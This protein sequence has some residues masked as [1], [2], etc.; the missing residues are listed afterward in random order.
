MLRFSL[1]RTAQMAIVVF[2]VVTLV[3]FIL[4][5]ASGDPA[6]L[7]VPPGQQEDLVQLTRERLGTD[8]PI[9]V[10]YGEYLVG[11]ARGD[12]GV[13]FHGGQPVLDEVL[14]ALPNTA[15]LAA[16]T[17]V[18]S[19]AV[20][21]VL[22]IGAALRANGAFDRVVLVY[23][24][25]ALATPSFWLAIVLVMFFSVRLGWLPAIDMEGPESFVLPVI[26]LAVALTPVLIRMIRLSFLETLSDDHV[27]AARARGIPERRVILVHGLKV[28]ALPLITLVGLQ[29]GLIL[30][31]SYVVE[32]VFNWPGIGKLT[33]DAVVSR[34]FPMIQGGVLVAALAFV[35][36]NF[37]VDLAYAAVDPRIRL[38]AR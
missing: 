12:L 3:F 19:S 32:F 25:V 24:S 11:L 5:L 10:Q 15:L 36:V 26:T 37:V 17:I 22:G 6:N 1:R 13:S 8:R 16:V 31:G 21:L 7:M 2:G 23:V 14:K 28:A 20:A 9:L 33:L 29:M 18:F 27:R 4:R 35:V 30:A 34:N 38:A